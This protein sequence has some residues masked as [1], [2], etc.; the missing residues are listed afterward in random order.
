MGTFGPV[1]PACD[2]ARS[3]AS[4]ELDGEL[5]ELERALL[6]SHLGKCAHCSAGVAEMRAFTETLRAAPLEPTAAPVFVARAPARAARSARV[7]TRIAVAAT[8]AALAGG[9][10]ALTGSLAD[11]PADPA[12]VVTDVALRPASADESREVREQRGIELVEPAKQRLFPP[13]RLGG[14]V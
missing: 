3:W 10:G 8:L 7:A 12:P 11:A 6:E 4:L 1:N 9:L 2:R 13:G 5:S 14:D